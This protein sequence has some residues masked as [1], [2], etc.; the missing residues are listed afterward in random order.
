MWYICFVS[1]KNLIKKNPQIIYTHLGKFTL[2]KKEKKKKVKPIFTSYGPSLT[3]PQDA[4]IS[5]MLF[6][7]STVEAKANYVIPN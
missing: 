6:L 2:L 7:C 4:Y 5:K 3:K 1:F